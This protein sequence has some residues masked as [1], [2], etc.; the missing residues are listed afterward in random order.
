[1][2]DKFL[3]VGLEDEDERYL[4]QS[5]TIGYD[6]VEAAITAYQFLVEQA[7]VDAKKRYYQAVVDYESFKKIREKLPASEAFRVVEA[8][9]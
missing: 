4:V 5:G 8:F 9:V 3:C 2:A 6:T 1:M 7:Y